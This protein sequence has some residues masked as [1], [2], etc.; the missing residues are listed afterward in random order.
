[1]HKL[2]KIRENTN[3]INNFGRLYS[4]RKKE[5]EENKRKNKIKYKEILLD[6]EF[7]MKK[8]E[9]KRRKEEK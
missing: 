3:K 8:I 4:N 1:M 7:K 6:L 2:K 9:N 5:I